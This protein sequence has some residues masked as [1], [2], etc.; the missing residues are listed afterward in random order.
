M[1]GVQKD[2]TLLKMLTESLDLTHIVK[3][4]EGEI[5]ANGKA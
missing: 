4:I 1:E 2:E 3:K 5:T